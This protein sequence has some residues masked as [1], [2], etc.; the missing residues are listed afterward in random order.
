MPDEPRPGA[1]AAGCGA[2]HGTGGAAWSAP[3][4]QEAQADPI[5]AALAGWLERRAQ[6]QRTLQPRPAQL[7]YWR[8]FEAETAAPM[9]R[10]RSLATD[11]A[12]PD[13]SDELDYMDYMARINEAMVQ[14]TADWL[15]SLRALDDALDDEQ[16]TRLDAFLAEHDSPLE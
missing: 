11:D 5:T 10:T 16:K 14:D 12:S 2:F 8:A 7:A 4:R 13:E 3:E 9:L 1:C 15:K 6:L